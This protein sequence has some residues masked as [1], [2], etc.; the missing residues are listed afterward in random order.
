ME[1]SGEKLRAISHVSQLGLKMD[2]DADCPGTV[3]GWGLGPGDHEAPNW[4]HEISPNPENAGLWQR[5]I[6]LPTVQS[7]GL[8]VCLFAPG[9]SSKGI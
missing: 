1:G 8:R 7:T 3:R 5:I 6:Q 4:K 9:L 2:W